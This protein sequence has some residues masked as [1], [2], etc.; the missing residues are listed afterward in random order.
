MLCL[1]Y[2]FFL[3]IIIMIYQFIFTEVKLQW[4]SKGILKM[5]VHEEDFH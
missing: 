5:D 3:L 2:I 1:S 4:L